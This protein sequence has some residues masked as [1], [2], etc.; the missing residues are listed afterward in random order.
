MKSI[1]TATLLLAMATA[2]WADV[3]VNLRLGAGHPIRRPARTV[4]VRPVRPAVVVAPRV[5]YAAPVVW[6][7][8]VVALPPRER[9]V[10]EDSETLQRREDWVDTTLAVNQNGD[11]LMLRVN[12]RLQV[13]FAEVH[14]RGGQA[15]VVDFNEAP[16]E[17]GTY[18]L[19]DF[20]DGRH[21][22]YVRVVARARS[23]NA[24]VSVLLAR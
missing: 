17:A 3:R 12:G 16:M 23:Q 24:K 15:Q 6:T 21:V 10:V 18:P 20:K 2:T 22:D 11:R 5:V 1:T 7:R 8:R 13:D 9:I 4:V 14:F 19:L